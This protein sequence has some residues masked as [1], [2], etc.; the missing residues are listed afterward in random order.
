MPGLYCADKNPIS[1]LIGTDIASNV[2]KVSLSSRIPSMK[3]RP[4][5]VD[6]ANTLIR[7]LFESVSFFSDATTCLNEMSPK[8]T[9]GYNKNHYFV[10]FIGKNKDAALVEMSRY[11]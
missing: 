7:D 1:L 9:V 8:I 6:T 3:Y 4:P 11:S 10:T 5:S 2:G